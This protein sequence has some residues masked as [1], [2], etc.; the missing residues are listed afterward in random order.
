ML[1]GDWRVGVSVG[2]TENGKPEIM[3]TKTSTN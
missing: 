3:T 1:G 2:V